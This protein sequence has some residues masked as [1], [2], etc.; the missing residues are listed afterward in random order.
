MRVAVT[1]V[2]PRADSVKAAAK[3]RFILQRVTATAFG[4]LAK[5]EDAFQGAARDL[6]AGLTKNPPADMREVNERA[7][8]LNVMCEQIA[9]AKKG[10]AIA[11]AMAG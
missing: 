8:T 1:L 2:T 11:A 10:P 4:A 6:D 9:K 7:N 3:D 5:S